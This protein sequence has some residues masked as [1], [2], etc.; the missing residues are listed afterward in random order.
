MPGHAVQPLHTVTSRAQPCLRTLRRKQFGTM[1]EPDL[2]S[3]KHVCALAGFCRRAGAN[4]VARPAGP[5]LCTL[6][7]ARKHGHAAGRRRPSVWLSCYGCLQVRTQWHDLL[8]R[9]CARF[10]E[11]RVV[12]MPLPEP[13]QWAKADSYKL[14]LSFD[15]ALLFEVAHQKPVSANANTLHP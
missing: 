7:C 14:M 10:L 12:V 13:T 9:H 4:A 5:P 15:C 3:R 11:D 8:G 1:N 2:C 6:S